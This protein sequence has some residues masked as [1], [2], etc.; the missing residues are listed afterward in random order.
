MFDSVVRGGDPTNIS[1]LKK[2]NTNNNNSNNL[3][4]TPN[5]HDHMKIATSESLLSYEDDE[6]NHHTTTEFNINQVVLYNKTRFTIKEILFPEDNFQ[7]NMYIVSNRRDITR[8]VNGDGISSL[9]D[10]PS[11]YSF[12]SN[13]SDDISFISSDTTLTSRKSYSSSRNSRS[14]SASTLQ[15]T[16]SAKVK[17][18]EI[19]LTANERLLHR[20]LNNK[21]A[22]CE[23]TTVKSTVPTPLPKTF[24]DNTNTAYGIFVDN[25][26]NS[27]VNCNK[28]HQMHLKNWCIL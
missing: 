6:E 12:T 16:E 8:T 22:I 9:P 25:N 13:I 14:S 26:K 7:D 28:V 21:S 23:A 20:L 1:P 17:A 4:N 27:N 3:N 18:M 5:N 15:V 10:S 11:Y 24:P 2:N 19:K